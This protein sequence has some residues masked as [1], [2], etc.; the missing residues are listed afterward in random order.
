MINRLYEAKT[1]FC[2]LTRAIAGT[3]IQRDL[4]V[5]LTGTRREPGRSVFGGPVGARR[6]MAAIGRVG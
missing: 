6:A 3:K 5:C 4:G 2:H 1:D